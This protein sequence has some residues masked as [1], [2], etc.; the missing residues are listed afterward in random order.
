MEDYL[1]EKAR[2]TTQLEGNRNYHI[3]YYLVH[4]ASESLAKELGLRR[5]V[6]SYRYLNPSNKIRTNT[7]SPST[8]EKDADKFRNMCRCLSIADVSEEEQHALWRVLSGI[9]ELGQIDFRY[10]ENKEIV[11]LDLENGVNA[12]VSQCAEMLGFDRSNLIFLLLHRLRVRNVSPY[13]HMH[14]SQVILLQ[15]ANITRHTHTTSNTGHTYGN[16]QGAVRKGITNRY[17]K[18][19]PPVTHSLTHTHTGTST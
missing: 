6:E 3:F 15:Y 18:I 9:L 11:Q 8:T 19:Q 16:N 17:L 4:G 13:R 5:H 12:C 1:L 7:D 2:V 14:H 10:D